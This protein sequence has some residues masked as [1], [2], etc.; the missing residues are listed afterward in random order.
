[1]DAKSNVNLYLSKNTATLLKYD[2]IT[3]KTTSIKQIYKIFL[4]NTTTTT[5]TTSISHLLTQLQASQKGICF[6]KFYI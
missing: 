2:L 5:T 6:P 4:S 1:M 3:R